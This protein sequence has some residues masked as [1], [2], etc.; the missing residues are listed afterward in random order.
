MTTAPDGRIEAVY[1]RDRRAAWAFVA[2]LWL[3]IGFVLVATWRLIDDPGVHLVLSAAA[4]LLLALNTA[5]IAAM[6]A[7]YAEDK[8]FIYGLD[9]K[10]LDARPG[11]PKDDGAPLRAAARR[12]A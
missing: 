3:V 8:A 4:V 11:R 1:R 5:S 2:T 10:H 7:H 6:V 12:G 9:L